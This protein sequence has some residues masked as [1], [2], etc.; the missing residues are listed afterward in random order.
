MTRILMFLY[1]AGLFFTPAHAQSVYD[2]S[3]NQLSLPS[4]QVGNTVFTDVVVTIDQ[5]VSAGASYTDSQ[6]GFNLLAA[7]DSQVRQSGQHQFTV[8]GEAAGVP[9]SGSGTVISGQ[10]SSGFF[11]GKAAQI[12]TAVVAMTLNANGSAVPVNSSSIAYYDSN[13]RFLGSEGESYEVV[14]IYYDLPAD[15]GSNDAGLIFQS[16]LYTNSSKLLIEGKKT[17]TYSTTFESATT[18]IL[19]VISVVR[20]SSG[21]I[22]QSNSQRIRIFA[23]NTAQRLSDTGIESSTFLTINYQ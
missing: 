4:V 9:V 2:A 7:Y 17:A 8:S 5:V 23:N 21:N 3:T 19:T 6:A 18:L 1:L 16:T 10:L 22:I 20:D 12:K 11:E 14:D 13:N 15:A